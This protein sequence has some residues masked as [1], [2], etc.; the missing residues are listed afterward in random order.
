[1]KKLV[2]SMVAAAIISFA[3]F[4]PAQAGVVNP[5]TMKPKAQVA[6][7][8]VEEVGRRGRRFRRG[9]A[10]GAGIVTLGILGALAAKRGHAYDRRY[11]SRY[12]RRCRR[13][14]RRCYRGNDRACWKFDS[15]C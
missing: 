1:M 7:S 3:G 10:I 9:A 12:E 2:L 5:T 4:A 14:R 6:D 8:L 15:R 13:W 11:E